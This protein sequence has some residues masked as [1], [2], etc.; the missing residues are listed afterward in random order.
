MNGCSGGPATDQFDV[1]TPLVTWVEQGQTPDSVVAS[2]RGASNPGG[3]NV[4]VP[5][6]WSPTR[7]RPPCSYPEVA[8]H[9]GSGSIDLASSFTCQ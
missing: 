9:N 1:L 6:A 3:A 2:A 8:R 4:D 7:T 5:V